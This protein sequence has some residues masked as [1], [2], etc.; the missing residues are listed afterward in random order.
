MSWEVFS[1][2]IEG[3]PG[4]ASW[5]QAFGSIA[6]IGIAIWV[7]YSQR[8]AQLKMT[9]KI[10]RDKVEALIAVVESAS[11]FI[12]VIGAL[13]EKKPPVFVFKENWKL[14][15]KNWLESSIHSLSQLPAHEFGRGD[16]VRGY[17]GIMAGIT[18]IRRLI[19][20]AIGADALE[21]QE[22][23]FMYQ[24]VLSQVRIVQATWRS[25]QACVG[26]GK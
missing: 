21:E 20:G 12:T 17:F 24:E 19:D 5:V 2:W 14:V 23:F 7:A 13:V 8:K 10:A 16:L 15:N 25:F 9:E 1:C 26:S 6:A 22:F 3:H 4:L 18:E 11:V